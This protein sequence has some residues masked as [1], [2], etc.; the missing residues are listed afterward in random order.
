MKINIPLD[1]DE[2]FYE[3]H[4]DGLSGKEAIRTSVINAIADRMISGHESELKE[5]IKKKGASI[6]AQ[7]LEKATE[8]IE[9][10]VNSIIESF[11]DEKLTITNDW[12]E[13]LVEDVRLEDLIKKKLK[14]SFEQ[15]VDK[16]GNVSTYNSNNKW[17]RAEYLAVERIKHEVGEAMKHFNK[18]LTE[19]VKNEVSESLKNHVSSNITNMVLK[20]ISTEQK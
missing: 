10:R 13:K 5:Q 16:E 18:D 2:L 11:L 8:K 9:A 1:L 15:K 4:A 12:G 14:E 3:S 7:F 19:K 6:E 17:T 20:Q